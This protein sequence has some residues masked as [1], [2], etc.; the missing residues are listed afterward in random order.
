MLSHSITQP[1]PAP[2]CKMT[3]LATRHYKKDV[4]SDD[5]SSIFLP[6]KIDFLCFVTLSPPL[7]FIWSEWGTY[8]VSVAPSELFE[9]SLWF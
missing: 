4:T 8:I 6:L 5:G 1:D 2:F 9:I 3:S 7:L